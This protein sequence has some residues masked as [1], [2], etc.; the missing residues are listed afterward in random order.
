[1]EG[2][3]RVVIADDH[4]IVR[5]GLTV[6]INAQQD[7]R[8]VGEASNGDEAVQRIRELRPDVTVMDLKMPVRDGL[9]AI[10]EV[11]ETVPGA[12]ILVLTSFSDDDNVFAAIKAGAVGFLLK[13]SPPESLLDAVRAIHRGEG[14]LHTSI[15][16][17]LMQE[18]KR[19]PEP[20]KSNAPLTPREHE[21][22]SYIAQGLSNREIADKMSVSI[23]TVTTH[24]GSILEKLHLANRTRAALYAVE[25]G[26]VA[27]PDG[28]A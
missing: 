6:T 22:L 11:T 19:P 14:A 4:P 26:L 9:S 16:R 18:I 15:A 24:V 27:K 12:R 25:Q 2:D 10:K 3:I 23:R 21:V 8:V 1:M 5:Q 17:K 7:M 28:T 13:D 20:V